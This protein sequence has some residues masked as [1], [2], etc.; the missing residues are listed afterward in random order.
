MKRLLMIAFAGAALTFL[1]PSA[2]AALPTC[3]TAVVTSTTAATAT[4]VMAEAIPITATATP[5]A[6]GTTVDTE[7]PDMASPGATTRLPITVR[8]TAVTTHRAIVRTDRPTV[9]TA[10]CILMSDACTSASV[11][12]TKLKIVD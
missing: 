2:E 1:I 5:V 6:T 10:V 3:I 7:L 9:V 4:W 12:I 11:D 8:P